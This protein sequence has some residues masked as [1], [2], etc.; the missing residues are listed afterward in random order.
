MLKKLSRLLITSMLILT[1]SVTAFA[2]TNTGEIIEETKE[3]IEKLRYTEGVHDYTAPD[4]EGEWLIKDGATDYQLVIPANANS[5][6]NSAVQEFKLL[7]AR[8]TN[9]DILAVKD[10]EVDWNEDSKYISF[11][12][13]Y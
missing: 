4:I 1:L 5:V 11:G 8:A 12:I 13:L 2:C 6:I 10:T 7:F 9:L 3:P